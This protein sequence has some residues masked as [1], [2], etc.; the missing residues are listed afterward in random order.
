MP[1]NTPNPDPLDEKLKS[2]NVTA[3]LPARFQENVWKR[4]VAL[5]KSPG[6][7]FWRAL[8]E[9]LARAF[10]RPAFASAYLALLLVVGLGT[11]FWQARAKTAEWDKALA[12]KYVQAVDPYRTPRE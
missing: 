12:E 4:M 10:L 3:P 5:D 9:W 2:W 8:E 11:G 1:E 6:L 7:S